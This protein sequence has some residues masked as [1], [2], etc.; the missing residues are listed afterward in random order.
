MTNLLFYTSLQLSYWDH[1]RFFFGESAW[2]PRHHEQPLDFSLCTIAFTMALPW[3][4][5]TC[6]LLNG[7]RREVDNSIQSSGGSIFN[8]F[9]YPYM[10][11]G[12]LLKCIVVL[13]WSK[14]LISYPILPILL[15]YHPLHSIGLYN[16]S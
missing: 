7:F 8:M 6:I 10:T 11:V 15:P 4:S 1:M 2:S 9:S 14:L 12:V 5:R 3:W 13:L 16:K